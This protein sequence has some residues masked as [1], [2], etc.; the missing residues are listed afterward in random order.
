MLLLLILEFKSF[1]SIFL[2]LKSNTAVKASLIYLVFLSP[3]SCTSV[4]KGK[5]SQILTLMNYV[6]F[7]R[8]KK[9][10]DCSKCDCRSV[11]LCEEV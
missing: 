6:Y 5:G 2:A 11:M 7:Y 9:K 10:S 1:S 4:N 3:P 8:K